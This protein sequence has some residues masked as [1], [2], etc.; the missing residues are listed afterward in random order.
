MAD[1]AQVEMLR[2][3]VA[4]W[5]KWR[6]ANAGI[7]TNLAYANLQYANLTNADLMGANLKPE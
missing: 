5:N 6:N 4:E 1:M 2:R 7:L 3:S